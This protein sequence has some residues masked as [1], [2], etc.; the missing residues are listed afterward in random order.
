MK[1]ETIGTKGDSELIW[2]EYILQT[3]SS[4]KDPHIPSSWASELA[5]KKT[6]KCE[7]D[8]LSLIILKRKKEED[9]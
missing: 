5:R 6:F 4:S 7:R 2:V 1:E 3:E 9:I 8:D